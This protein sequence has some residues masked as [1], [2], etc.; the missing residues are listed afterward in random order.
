MVVENVYDATT[1]M[2]NN[3]DEKIYIYIYY[4]KKRGNEYCKSSSADEINGARLWKLV[5]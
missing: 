2:L 5:K 1:K 4:L 3:H